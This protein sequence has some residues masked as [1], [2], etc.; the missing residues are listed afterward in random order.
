ML[1]NFVISMT[2]AEQRREHI[3]RE[4][5]KHNIAFEFFDAITPGDALDKTIAEFAP[6]LINVHSLSNGEK[7]CFMSHVLLWQKC[8]ED[9]LPYI[10][11]YED[12]VVLGSDAQFFFNTDSWIK[13]LFPDHNEFFILRPETYLMKVG[14]KSYKTIPVSITQPNYHSAHSTYELNK[15]T[16]KHY[17][18][19]CYII[20][21]TS[22]KFLLNLLQTLPSSAFNPVDHILFRNYLS[23]KELPVY[24]LNPALA[25]QEDI[26]C[27]DTSQLASDIKK[28]RNITRR[29][30]KEKL[31]IF[32][33]LI[34]EIKKIPAALRKAFTYKIIE[35]KR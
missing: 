14:L 7:A 34:R 35:F 10:A 3:R 11:I 19:A 21:N 16:S 30:Q 2:S 20:S 4:F 8:I 1:K 26:F 31:S 6:N 27:K 9:N 28:D 29:T 15:L 24:Q 17:G 33:K 22:A 18:T 25:I 32:Q 5:G 13:T 23:L 12:D